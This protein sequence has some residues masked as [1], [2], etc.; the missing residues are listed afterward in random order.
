MNYK[1]IKETLKARNRVLS[2]L[3]DV[4][5]QCQNCKRCVIFRSV[6]KLN[7]Y[8]THSYR[9]G[10]YKPMKED[11]HYYCNIKKHD[12]LKVAQCKKFEFRA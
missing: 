6:Y 11:I 5:V 12:V 2:L 8:T 1:T 9:Y 10:K 7:G 3:L 4:N